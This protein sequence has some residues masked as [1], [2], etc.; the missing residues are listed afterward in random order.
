MNIENIYAKVDYQTI[1]KKKI[2]TKFACV[3]ATSTILV[4][5]LFYHFLM[6]KYIPKINKTFNRGSFFKKNPMKKKER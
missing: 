3:Y 5:L 4:K 1:K 2:T 6:K